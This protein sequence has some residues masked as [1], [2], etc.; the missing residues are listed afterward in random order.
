MVTR[1]RNIVGAYV[2]AP[3]RVCIILLKLIFVL[4]V[5]GSDSWR[6]AEAGSILWFFFF[7]ASLQIGYDI[8]FL[9]GYT[10]HVRYAI[11][12]YSMFCYLWM[13][14]G[15]SENE[16]WTAGWWFDASGH[17]LSPAVNAQLLLIR[18]SI[19][20]PHR[21]RKERYE[22]EER[23]FLYVLAFAVLWEV[24]ELCVDVL[25]SAF[26]WWAVRL[27]KGDMDTVLDIFFSIP[28]GVASIVL[29]RVYDR[30]IKEANPAGAEEVDV[31]MQVLEQL[32]EE[33]DAVDGEVAQ[34]VGYI[35][36]LQKKNLMLFTRP[37]RERFALILRR[38]KKR[39]Y[40]KTGTVS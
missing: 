36:F 32:M 28:F 39:K 10:G 15:W 29:W 7:Y 13:L 3:I 19:K 34:Q 4:W 23:V 21:W 26:G 27:Q 17:M 9:L 30:H 38:L 16:L 22:V 5:F 6:M 24:G 40:T 14:W 2:P 8:A 25:Q 31:E 12:F 20:S 18:L 1:I 33:R 11:S 35:R 37:I